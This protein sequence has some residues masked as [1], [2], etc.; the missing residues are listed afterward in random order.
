VKCRGID[1][2]EGVGIGD[3]LIGKHL[4][5]LL[6][7]VHSWLVLN[8][9]GKLQKRNGF[10][11]ELQTIEVWSRTFIAGIDTQVHL[12]TD[13]FTGAALDAVF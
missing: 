5:L 12:R 4:N 13:Y 7:L 11:L 9:L 6:L 8:L 10:P 3:R 1:L 2:T